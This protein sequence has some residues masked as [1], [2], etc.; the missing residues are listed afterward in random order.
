MGVRKHIT[1]KTKLASTLLALGDIPYKHGKEMTEDQIISLYHWDHN[2][3][4]VFDDND[5]FW[6]IT[7]MLIAAHR[8]KSAID[9]AIVAKV[10][11]L[12][13]PKSKQPSRWPQGRKLQSRGFERRKK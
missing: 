8:K 7:P 2:I 12:R 11:R 4:H 6:N 1:L 5:L 13:A 9:Q 10:K 3:L